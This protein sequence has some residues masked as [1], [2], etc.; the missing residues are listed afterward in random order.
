[1]GSGFFQNFQGCGEGEG[2]VE[3]R[4]STENFFKDESICHMLS[5]TLLWDFRKHM[6]NFKGLDAWFIPTISERKHKKVLIWEES[7]NEFFYPFAG[8]SN[9]RKKLIVKIKKS[10]PKYSERFEVVYLRM[11]E[12]SIES[13]MEELSETVILICGSHGDSLFELFLPRY[14]TSLVLVD[15]LKY[16]YRKDKEISDLFSHISVRYFK[17]PSLDLSKN[18][19]IVNQLVDATIEGFLRFDKENQ[20]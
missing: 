7:E 6:M 2:G 1:M 19:L 3:V 13:Q 4:D 17:V 16:D 20:L 14:S 5:S 11:E 10:Y 9:F 18:S 15:S 12:L 8:I